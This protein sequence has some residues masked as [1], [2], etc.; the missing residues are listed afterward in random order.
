MIGVACDGPAVRGAAVGTALTEAGVLAVP[1][2]AGFASAPRTLG[3]GAIMVRI[4]ASLL[5]RAPEVAGAPS[6]GVGV[7]HEPQNF[8]PATNDLPHF[9]QV[10]VPS[11]SN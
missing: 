5:S 3:A 1:L 6:V 11:P 9:A 8:A 2:A 10:I 7:P 4:N